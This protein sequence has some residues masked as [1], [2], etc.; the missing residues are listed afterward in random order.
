MALE[1]QLEVGQAAGG[2]NAVSLGLKVKDPGT[3]QVAEIIPRCK[4]LDEF[5][6]EIAR[7]KLELD[8]SLDRAQREMKALSAG[9]AGMGSIDPREAW[10]KMESLPSDAEM[11]E[12]FNAFS[13]T[14]RD[15]IAEYILS[16]VNMFKGRGPVFSEHYD[17]SSR[18][19]E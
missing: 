5:R 9:G 7:I 13:E 8:K 10:K 19:L 11:F 18:I 6:T 4:S 16:H 12:Y 1:F 3:G 2:D 17:A 15:L 14:D